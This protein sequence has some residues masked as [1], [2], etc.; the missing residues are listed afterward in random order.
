LRT[1]FRKVNHWCSTRRKDWSWFTGRGHAGIVNILTLAREEFPN[2]AVHESNVAGHS[3]AKP[4]MVHAHDTVLAMGS[5]SVLDD[6]A[7]RI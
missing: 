7:Q 6:P 5:R 2:E 4:S 1:Q 3:A